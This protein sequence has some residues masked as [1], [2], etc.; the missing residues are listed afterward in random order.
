MVLEMIGGGYVSIHQ[1]SSLWGLLLSGVVCAAEE[2]MV[3]E[4]AEDGSRTT[5]PFTVTDG[6]EV[7]RVP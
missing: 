1:R 2:K 5:R 7:R 6:W 3:V 4:L